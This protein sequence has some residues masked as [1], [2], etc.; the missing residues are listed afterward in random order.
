[1]YFA[2]SYRVPVSYPRGCHV[3]CDHIHYS[4]GRP[5]YV[6]ELFVRLLL[7][8]LAEKKERW[9]N[10]APARNSK[11]QH[12]GREGHGCRPH[13]SSCPAYAADRPECGGRQDAR[14]RRHG[15]RKRLDRRH[16]PYRNHREV[17]RAS[18]VRQQSVSPGSNRG[19]FLGTSL[20]LT[21][22]SS[23]SKV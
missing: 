10:A 9:R 22:P 23:P 13:V 18:S 4:D 2:S 8:H 1:M 12:R 17:L 3:Y 7:H 14:S 21:L 20:K 16:R 19:F 6:H 11:A 5:G 15:C